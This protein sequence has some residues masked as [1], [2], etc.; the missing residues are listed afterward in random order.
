[1]LYNQL[2]SASSSDFVMHPCADDFENIAE[3]GNYGNYEQIIINPMIAEGVGFGLE[4]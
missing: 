1:M 4:I 2:L 3:K